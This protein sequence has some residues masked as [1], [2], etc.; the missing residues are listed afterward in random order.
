VAPGEPVK[1]RNLPPARV[2]PEQQEL[3]TVPSATPVDP[4]DNAV[5]EQEQTESSNLEKSSLEQDTAPENPVHVVIDGDTSLISKV[6]P[7]I[8]PVAIEKLLNPEWLAQS[9]PKSRAAAI[10]TAAQ[11][12]MK[13]LKGSVKLTP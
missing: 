3:P 4:V 12:L 8:P 13:R 2:V 1:P 6:R 10:D 9:T 11:Q 5:T 7:I